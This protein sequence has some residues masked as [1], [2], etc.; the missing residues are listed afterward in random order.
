VLVVEG[1][2][3]YS[4]MVK[5]KLPENQP[6]QSGFTLLEMVIAISIFAVIGAIAYVTLDRFLHTRETLDSHNAATSQLQRMIG[7]FERD[8]RF[9]ANRTVRDGIGEVLPALQTQDDTISGDGELMGLT[10]LLPS[11]LSPNWQRPQRVGW[12]LVDGA[13]VRQVWPV[14]DRDFDSAARQTI[15]LTQVR[16][17]ELRYLS[18]DG[19]S[20]GL[21]AENT[22]SH[23]GAL[24]LAVE[25]ILTL[26][27][28]TTYRR[29]VEVAGVTY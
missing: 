11:Y 24:P 27:D 14:L 15:L 23:A 29:L 10:V 5:F 20:Q 25:L 9:M 1:N 12:L 18:R 7:Q 3:R 22:W 4:S 8:V 26:E 16:T 13:V 28:D 21:K 6:P 19:E 17:I 2:D